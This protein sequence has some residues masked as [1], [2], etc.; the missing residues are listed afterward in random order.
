[1]SWDVTGRPQHHRPG[2]LSPQAAHRNLQQGPHGEQ[3]QL[4]QGLDCTLQVRVW[5]YRTGGLEL[6]KWFREEIFSVAIHPD[7]LYIA[8]GFADKD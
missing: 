1:M 2:R 5:N 6:A 3:S 8:A 4:G 7:G